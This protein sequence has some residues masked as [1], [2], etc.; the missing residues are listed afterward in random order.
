M[1]SY[2][3]AMILASTALASGVTAAVTEA[4]SPVPGVLEVDLIFPR[5]GSFQPVAQMPVVFAL[6]NPSLA[7]SLD[8]DLGWDLTNERNDTVVFLPKSYISLDS[9]VEYGNSTSPFAVYYLPFNTSG[10][11][12]TWTFTWGVSYTKWDRAS[13]GLLESTRI[14]DG[15]TVVF[16]TSSKEMPPNLQAA[17]S[18]DACAMSSHLV[19]NVTEILRNQSTYQAVFG[20]TPTASPCAVSINSAAASSMSASIASQCSAMSDLCPKT[21]SGRQSYPQPLAGVFSSLAITFSVLYLFP[22]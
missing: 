5:N 10:E 14:S 6:Q 12:T 21:S 19:Y 4:T 18:E 13:N 22:I 20:A 7:T 2:I 9:F 3:S 8:G 1:I 11:E 16:T 17:A 15:K